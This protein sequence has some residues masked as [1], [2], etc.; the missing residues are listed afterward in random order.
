[1]I[2]R[3]V[4]NDPKSTSDRLK[5]QEQEFLKNS[6][7]VEPDAPQ[8]GTHDRNGFKPLRNREGDFQAD[9]SMLQDFEDDHNSHSHPLSDG[10]KDFEEIE[11][12]DIPPPPNHGSSPTR[13][14]QTERS[15]SSH[16]VMESYQKWLQHHREL[17]AK[18]Q[19]LNLIDFQAEKL[20]TPGLRGGPQILKTVQMNNYGSKTAQKPGKSAKTK[21]NRIKPGPLQ[22][23]RQTWQLQMEKTF[24]YL[25]DQLQVPYAQTKI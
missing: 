4:F 11:I 3:E 6:E 19:K 23:A 21:L 9:I 25:C 8:Y 13:R 10:D 12:F 16:E 2:S 18:I 22:S 1:M 5:N 15:A 24:I 17:L 14:A 20:Q 7:V